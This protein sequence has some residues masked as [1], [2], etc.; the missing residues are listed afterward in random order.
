MGHGRKK[1]PQRQSGRRHAGQKTRMA[2]VEEQPDT[3]PD[4]QTGSRNLDFALPLRHE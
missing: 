3:K 4:H 1:R 2:A